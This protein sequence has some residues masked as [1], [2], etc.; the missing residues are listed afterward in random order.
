MNRRIIF[1]LVQKGIVDQQMSRL[2]LSHPLNL[3]NKSFLI[4]LG[5][6]TPDWVSTIA[7]PE[8]GL[9]STKGPGNGHIQT[10]E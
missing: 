5:L 9:L 7:S 3:G 10:S 2:I 6:S 4:H 1:S 8:S